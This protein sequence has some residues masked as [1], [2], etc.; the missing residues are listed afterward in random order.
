MN[1]WIICLVLLGLAVLGFCIYRKRTKNSEIS[2]YWRDEEEP[3][4]K[5]DDYSITGETIN[6]SQGAGDLILDNE[7]IVIIYDKEEEEELKNMK[8]E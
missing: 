6:W 5:G 8:E 3:M 7:P 2:I 1:M 4:K